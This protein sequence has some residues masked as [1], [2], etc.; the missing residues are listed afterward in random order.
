MSQDQDR[1]AEENSEDKSVV[2]LV[3]PTAKERRKATSKAR[4]N[5]T[6]F[7]YQRRELKVHSTDEYLKT[8][9]DQFNDKMRTRLQ[10][11]TAQ[12]KPPNP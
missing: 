4:R 8:L 2:L 10:N 7:F 12:V 5:N 1:F 6:T 9:N 11:L 3:K